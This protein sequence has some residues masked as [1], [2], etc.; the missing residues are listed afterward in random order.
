MNYIVDLNPGPMADNFVN[1]L[2]RCSQNTLNQLIRDKHL[3]VFNKFP[4]T[5]HISVCA[6]SLE[7]YIEA[8]GLPAS[9]FL[10]GTHKP[11]VPCYT[12]F[13]NII[14]SLLNGMSISELNVLWDAARLFFPNP[15]Y[16]LEEPDY[17]QRTIALLRHFISCEMYADQL[18]IPSYKNLDAD[19]IRE[20]LKMAQ[21]RKYTWIKL[22]TANLIATFLGVSM[23]WLLNIRDHNLFC[24]HPIADRIFSYYT[25]LSEPQQKEFLSYLWQCTGS[26]F[27][28]EAKLETGGIVYG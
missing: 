23:H 6:S 15:I 10:Y 20:F 28:A 16:D 13:D 8:T 2:C 5:S 18:Y 14:I 7:A 27:I 19:L 22:D 11:F 17:R 25:L 12:P 26:E 21:K 9:Y 4:V 1:A 24:A 3:R